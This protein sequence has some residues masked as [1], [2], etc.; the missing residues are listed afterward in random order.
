MLS[1]RRFRVGTVTSRSGRLLHLFVSCLPFRAGGKVE[2]FNDVHSSGGAVCCAHG[3]RSFERIHEVTNTRNE[4]MIGTTCAFS[5]ALLGGCVQLGRRLSL[6][7]VSPTH[8][9]RRFTR[10]R[11]GG[12]RQSFRAGTDRLLGHFKYVYQLGRFAPISAPIVFMTR[13]GRRGDGITGGPLTTMLNSMGTGGHLP[14][15]LAFGTSGR[16]I[17]ALLEVRKS[18]GL[19]RRIIR[20]LCMRSLLRKG[21]PI[22]DRRVR[23]F[24]RSLSRLVATGVGSFVGFLGWA[25]T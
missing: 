11:N 12:R 10:M 24:G 14:P 16:V 6:R 15:A 22:G 17:R 9:L 1:I 4:L 19:F 5:R 21:C 3:L 25:G 23:L 13:R 2:D 7:R 18:G 20:V 8:L